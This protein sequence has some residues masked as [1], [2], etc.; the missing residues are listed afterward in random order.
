MEDNDK[1]KQ[2]DLLY[3]YI[4]F[5]LGLYIS[6]PPVLAILATALNVT[7]ELVFQYSMVGLIIIFFIAGVHA[8]WFIA[9]HI[10]IKWNDSSKWLKFG[11]SASSFKRR[12]IHHYFYWAGLIIGLGGLIYAWINKF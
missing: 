9:D 7:N 2:S 3:D 12:I 4:K 1:F 10:N 11:C 5:H 6:T 8:S